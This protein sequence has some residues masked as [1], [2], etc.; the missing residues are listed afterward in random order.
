MPENG[1]ADCRRNLRNGKKRGKGR[2]CKFKCEKGFFLKRNKGYQDSF[3]EVLVWNILNV[4]F[5][6]IKTKNIEKIL[7]TKKGEAKPA[8]DG[9]VKCTE[10]IGWQSKPQSLE[11]LPKSE[12]KKKKKDKTDDTE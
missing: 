12:R 6:K 3:F 9:V 2:K 1:L 7:K 4:S 10:N 8:K 5:S 11:C